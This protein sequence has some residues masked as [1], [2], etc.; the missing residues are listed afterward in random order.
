MAREAPRRTLRTGLLVQV[1]TICTL[2]AIGAAAG[3]TGHD[4]LRATL[5]EAL[6]RGEVPDAL[7]G[8]LLRDP[9]PDS[10]IR[11]V[12][13]LAST[14]APSQLLR[15]TM[16]AR[17]R[18]PR[19]REQVMLAA[20]RMGAPAAEL[21]RSALHDPSPVVRR[22]A[23]W[24]GAEVGAPC[25]DAV[26]S[27]V[28][29][30]RDPE[31]LEM[32]LAN[33]WRLPEGRWEGLAGSYAAHPDPLLRRAAAYG[34]SRGRSPQRLPPLRRL[35]GDPEPVIRLT[36]L[37]GLGGAPPDP[38]DIER[39][40]AA[41][42]DA[43]WR[44]RMASCMVLAAT[45]AGLPDAVTVRLA[46]LAA[47]P[48]AQLAVAAIRALGASPARGGD[49]VLSTLAKRSEPWPAAEALAALSRHG[50]ATARELA[51]AWAASREGWRR[52]AAARAAVLETEGREA[53]LT[54]AL[55]DPD[56]GVRLAGLDALPAEAA[57]DRA[58]V[59]QLARDPDPAVRATLVARLAG[60]GALKP[61]RLFALAGS[62]RDDAA[63]DARAAAL[64]G[65][66]KLG[67]AREKAKAL[68]AALD[69]PDRAVAAQVVAAVRAAGE[70]AELPP[71]AAPHDPAW[72]R[73]LVRWSQRE[74]WL[75]VVT[76]RGTVRL[77]LE[78][79]RTPLTARAIWDLAGKGFYDGLT[80]HRVVP[81]FVVQGGD[82]RGDGW[83]GPGFTLVDEP[84]LA[85]FDSWRVGI[86]TSGP[87]TG[88]CQLFATLTPADH[89]TGHYTNVAEVT[90]GRD[91]LERIE[92][93]D[94]ILR[95]DTAEGQEPPPPP[96]TLVGHLEW[97]DLAGIEGWEAER[98]SYS[99]DPD[100]VARLRSAAGHYR[101][102]AVLGSW[103]SDSRREVP[104][105][106]KVVE[107]VGGGV[108]SL[109]LEGVDRTKRVAPGSP[110]AG[111]LP[112]GAA[113][114]VP[115]L[116]V[117]DADGQELGRVVETA[118][119]PLERLLVEL[120]APAEGWR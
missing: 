94:R 14:A 112:D 118:P 85:P 70:T 116:V 31:V 74:H 28:G 6:D 21:V 22:A 33:L 10:R 73:E 119:E 78:S 30:E 16:L 80:F 102:A 83:G 25:A 41:L 51:N 50:V 39:L 105:L 7:W 95:V 38:S 44:V 58:L 47:A 88:G 61:E 86:A 117:L 79:A 114:R 40:A 8:G 57:V 66:W 109:D 97:S 89:L 92:V 120:L 81:N 15:L 36:A 103:C 17:D 43:D 37:R 108:F 107:S 104:R 53:A 82:P 72:Y 29:A 93:G 13:V 32:A 75:D 11:A 64:L 24:A 48:R 111:L 65:A 106:A 62:W 96:P 71:R 101:I 115:T 1:L 60:A 87:A 46:E 20:G 9:N 12:A 67:D 68:T 27:A 90:L 55:A 49:A 56:P 77:R 110:A 84:S 91:V 98:A 5:L 63:G 45:P 2:T 18:D 4:L 42:D 26:L 23:V 35:V 54:R 52:R 3:G 34:L 19:V 113:E 76:A 59:E 69:D 99:P 100:A